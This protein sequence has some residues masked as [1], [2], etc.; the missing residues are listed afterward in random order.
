MKRQRQL[1]LEAVSLNMEYR[2]GVRQQKGPQAK[3]V[4]LLSMRGRGTLTCKYLAGS[5]E[6][7]LEVYQK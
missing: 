2:R 5:G 6:H 1:S 3:P 4:D 7:G